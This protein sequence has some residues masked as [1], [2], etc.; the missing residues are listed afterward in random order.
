MILTGATCIAMVI[1][2]I[3]TQK[4][5]LS[6]LGIVFCVIYYFKILRRIFR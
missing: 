1:A 5:W 4:W 2:G 6:S 3:Y